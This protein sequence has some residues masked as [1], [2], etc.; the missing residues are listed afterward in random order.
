MRNGKTVVS[1][2][3]YCGAVMV[4]QQLSSGKCSWKI[5]LDRHD[6]ENN[7]VIGV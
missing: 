2:M 7:C 3:N 6:P 1:T 4:D 5:R